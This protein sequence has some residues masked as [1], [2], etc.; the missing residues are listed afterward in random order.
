MEADPSASII[1][2]MNHR[3]RQ[4]PLISEL[5]CRT[6]RGTNPCPTNQA[7]HHGRRM[8][9]VEHLHQPHRWAGK[10]TETQNTCHVRCLTPPHHARL[11]ATE[12]AMGSVGVVHLA[13]TCFCG[14]CWSTL[15]LQDPVRHQPRPTRRRRPGP[16]RTWGFRYRK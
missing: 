6:F 13:P 9:C 5:D 11:N 3:L 4:K 15:Q 8:L 14:V 1:A 2:L 16:V 12:A 7:S 10:A